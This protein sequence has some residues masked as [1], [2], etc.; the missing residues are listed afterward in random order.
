VGWGPKGGSRGEAKKKIKKSKIVLGGGGLQV[1]QKKVR[2][3]RLEGKTFAVQAQHRGFDG[4]HTKA[5][6]EKGEDTT[7]KRR[8]GE[9]KRERRTAIGGGFAWG[10]KRIPKKD[11][12]MKSGFEKAKKRSKKKN[13][14]ETNQPS[15]TPRGE[16]LKQPRK[17]KGRTEGWNVKMGVG[18]PKKQGYHDSNVKTENHIKLEKKR[19]VQLLIPA[20]KTIKQRKGGEGGKRK[21]EKTRD[22]RGGKQ[23][24]I[25]RQGRDDGASTHKSQ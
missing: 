16:A 7:K 13:P 2:A 15:S 20:R 22:K 4:Q 21:R 12:G 11:A 19:G 23:G 14:T 25:V 10:R 17:Q 6:K 8:K 18:N 24:A 3:K 1:A 9:G 5:K